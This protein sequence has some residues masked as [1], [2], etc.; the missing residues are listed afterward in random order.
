L[1]I[2]EYYG[3]IHGQFPKDWTHNPFRLLEHCGEQMFWLNLLM[4]VSLRELYR[5]LDGFLSSK[6]EF[7]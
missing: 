7:I 6:S 2:V 3:D 5:R 1:H 4:L